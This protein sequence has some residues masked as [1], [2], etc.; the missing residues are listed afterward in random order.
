MA[1][2][3]VVEE[4]EEGWEELAAGEEEPASPLEILSLCT[5]KITL[6]NVCDQA[7]SGHTSQASG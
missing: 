7:M 4:E 2:V 6:E 5:H 1:V 3:G